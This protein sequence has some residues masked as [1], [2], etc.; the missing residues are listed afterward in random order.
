MSGAEVVCYYSLD[1]IKQAGLD[2]VIDKYQLGAL[3]HVRRL[4]CK[5]HCLTNKKSLSLRPPSSSAT[6]CPPP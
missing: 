4:N 6:W 1:I 2:K 3:V 5:H